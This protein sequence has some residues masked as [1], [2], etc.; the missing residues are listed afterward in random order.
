MSIL[1]KARHEPPTRNR[2]SDCSPMVSF[3]ASISAFTALR[4]ADLP[5]LIPRS[6][7]G[8]RGE[9]THLP[10]SPSFN[11]ASAIDDPEAE[12]GLAQHVLPERGAVLRL[13][14]RGCGHSRQRCSS[15]A[16]REKGEPLECLQCPYPAVGV[17]VA[18]FGHAAAEP[19]HDLFIEEIGRASGRAVEDDEADGVRA[20]IDDPDPSQRQCAR[21]VE[22][23]PSEWAPV[24]LL[25]RAAVF[26][27]WSIPLRR[28][29]VCPTRAGGVNRRLRRVSSRRTRPPSRGP[30]ARGSP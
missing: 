21:A 12:A 22:E 20:D 26:H 14:H 23:G 6:L 28:M 1:A 2:R 3:S 9:D 13:P 30:K 17:E 15:H 24:V 27:Q 10:T 7:K 19:A 11:S 25:R 5:P 16:L 8:P 18:G 29:A 4:L